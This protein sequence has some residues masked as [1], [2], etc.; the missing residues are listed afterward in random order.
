MSGRTGALIWSV[1]GTARALVNESN[2]Y[3]AQYIRDVDVDG[4]PDLVVAHGGDP[5]KE[6]GD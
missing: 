4:V 5:L 3:T 2:M 6:P 1:S